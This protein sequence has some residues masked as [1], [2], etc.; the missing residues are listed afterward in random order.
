[1][2]LSSFV[3]N[4]IPTPKVWRKPKIR[5][6][7]SFPNSSSIETP[8]PSKIEIIVILETTPKE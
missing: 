1:M 2:I 7:A 4:H 5:Q 6:K 3:S 8:P